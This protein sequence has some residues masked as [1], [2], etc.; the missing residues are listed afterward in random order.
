MY[1]MQFNVGQRSLLDVLDSISEVFTN[2]VLLETAQSNRN[3]S[4]YKILTLQGDL[5][6]SLEIDD[7]TYKSIP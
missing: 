1:L 4:V 5:I 7:K 6:K 3:F 2:N